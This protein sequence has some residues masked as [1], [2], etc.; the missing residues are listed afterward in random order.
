MNTSSVINV[1]IYD[2]VFMKQKINHTY[3]MGMVKQINV[4]LLFLQ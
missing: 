4:N 1:S 2:Y 3:K